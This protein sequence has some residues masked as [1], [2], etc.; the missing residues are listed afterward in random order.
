[1]SWLENPGLQPM[2]R[3]GSYTRRMISTLTDIITISIP[4][5]VW[6]IR[7]DYDIS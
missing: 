2:L 6:I 7:S 5:F 3:R 1:M 4:A